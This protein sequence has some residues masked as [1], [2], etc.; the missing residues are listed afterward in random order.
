MA[1]KLKYNIPVSWPLRS[2]PFLGYTPRGA[3]AN[4]NAGLIDPLGLEP[5]EFHPKHAAALGLK[6]G[7]P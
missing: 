5:E 4:I 2:A 7:P 6:P 1:A 3:R